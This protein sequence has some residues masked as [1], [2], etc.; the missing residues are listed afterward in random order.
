[1][2]LEL[3][4]ILTKRFHNFTKTQF[5]ETNIHRKIVTIRENCYVLCRYML[6]LVIIS[7]NGA[8][9]TYFREIVASGNC[10]AIAFRCC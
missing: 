9:L 6:V 8:F 7:V 4:L 2:V 5:R 3:I 10:R 1:M